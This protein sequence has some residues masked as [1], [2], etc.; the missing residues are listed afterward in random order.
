MSDESGWRHEL[1]ADTD[2][3]DHGSRSCAV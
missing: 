3:A 2:V 1:G